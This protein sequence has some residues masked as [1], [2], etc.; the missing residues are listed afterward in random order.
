VVG[1]DEKMAEEVHQVL[2]SDSLISARVKWVSVAELRT[3]DVAAADIVVIEPNDRPA[4]GIWTGRERSLVMDWVRTS[5]VTDSRSLFE[6]NLRYAVLRHQFFR[7]STDWQQAQEKVSELDLIRRQVTPFDPRTGWYSHAHIIDRCQEEIARALRYSLPIALVV[8]DIVSLEGAGLGLSADSSNS[9]VT[10]LAGRIRPIC[11]H[12]DVLGHYGPSSIL[13]ILLNTDHQGGE[14][15]SERAHQALLPPLVVEGE[16]LSL[17]W[18]MALSARDPGES[19]TPT[20]LLN[21]L[22]RRVE[23]ARAIGR[24]GVVMTDAF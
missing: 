9:L 23:R 11:R 18:A 20:E 6:V 1:Q 8:V 3:G 13:V 22:E 15:F 12:G 16:S 7:M 10:A 17:D 19:V 21:Q 5:A 4:L 24:R 14:R 2:A